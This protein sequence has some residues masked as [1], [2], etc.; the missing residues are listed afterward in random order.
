MGHSYDVVGVGALNVD[1]IYEAD[2]EEIARILGKNIEQGREDF[3]LEKFPSLQE[4][5]KSDGKLLK[6]SGGGSAANCVYALAGMGFKCGYIGITGKD[7]DSDFL[8][9]ELE[10]AGVDV[11]RVIR[12]DGY[13]GVCISVVSG[14]GRTMLIYTN[15]NDEFEKGKVKSIPFAEY[16]HFT[17]FACTLGD[18]P[19]EAQKDIAQQAKRNGSGISF[20][21]GHIYAKRGQDAFR[22]MIEN[23]DILFVNETEAGLLGANSIKVPI[24]AIKAGERGSRIYWS[25]AGTKMEAIIQ[26]HDIG[27]PV[28]GT[29]AGDVFDA[30]F[31]AARIEGAGPTDS[32]RFG[33]FVAAKSITKPGREAYPTREDF[34]AF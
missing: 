26:P 7:E 6:R 18:G 14:S 8:M 9:D 11:S 15:K 33:N 30:G 13:C 28:D 21:P 20:D 2:L 32:A 3:Y 19:L 24:V 12:E 1:L 17:S 31:L 16:F 34:D 27:K 5:L 22:E 29:G 10:A 23:T 4:Y 25:Y